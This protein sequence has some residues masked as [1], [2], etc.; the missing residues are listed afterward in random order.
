LSE[1][2]TQKIEEFNRQLVALKQE[3]NQLSNEARNW[4]E[5]RNA[6]HEQIKTL[7]REAKSLKE[8]RDATNQK[9]RELKS[10]R[11]QSRTEQKE[12]RAQ[13]SKTKEKMQVLLEKKPPRHLRDIQKDI[14]TIDWKIQTTP[15]SVKEEKVLV[16]QVRT[17][18]KQRVIQKRLQEL[19]NTT[20]TMQSEERALA[21]RAKLSH[22]KLEELAEQSQKF[23]EQMV[24]QLTMAQNLKIKADT[25][26]QKYLELR[27]KANETHQKYVKLLQQIDSLRQEIQ[28]KNEEQQAKRQQELLEEATKKAQEKMKRG[29][30][31]TWD[32]FKLLTE[33]E[34][35]TEP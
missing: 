6:I 10:L 29:Q 7:R 13:L 28:K 18:E 3:R 27:Q 32:E 34:P 22:E 9:V 15:L 17:L 5:K 1:P 20:M 30:K 25:A 14:E 2:T 26:H 31:L 11:E 16:D 8:K 33:Q 4:A 19:K 12:K 24:N 35:A 21:T 23:H